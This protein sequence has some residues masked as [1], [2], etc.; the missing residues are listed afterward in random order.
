[1]EN[2]G[3][4]FLKEGLKK[5][6]CTT[7]G[8]ITV[9][10]MK[11]R[12]R[13]HASSC[14]SWPL[15]GIAQPRLTRSL[16]KPVRRRRRKIGQGTYEVKWIVVIKAPVLRGAQICAGLAPL[17]KR[18]PITTRSALNLMALGGPEN[19]T[20][21]HNTIHPVEVIERIDTSSSPSA[22]SV[23]ATP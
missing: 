3:G 11:T 4:G 1:M 22:A 14:S 18:S 16:N 12:F 17:E 19:R 2:R 15:G 5:A 7:L 13:D 23:P 8:A 6:I 20:V 9:G 21:R 10:I